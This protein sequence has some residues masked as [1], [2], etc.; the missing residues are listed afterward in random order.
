MSSERGHRFWSMIDTLAWVLAI[1]ASV[2]VALA[3]QLGGIQVTRVLSSSMVPTFSPG[4]VLL[5][6]PVDRTSINPGDIPMLPDPEQAG[7]QYVHRAVQVRS[8]R[9]GE[10]WVVTRGDNNPSEDRPITIVS[11]QVPVVIARIPLSLLE[12]KAV[13]WRWSVPALVGLIAVA[14]VLLMEPIVRRRRLNAGDEPSG[15]SLA[16]APWGSAARPPSG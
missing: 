9:P 4:D 15:R 5:V 7:V 3:V 14:L 12:L 16:P 13:S 2:A 10:T 8:S 11:D 6:R 1:A